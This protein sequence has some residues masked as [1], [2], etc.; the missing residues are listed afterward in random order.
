M[1]NNSQN[2]TPKK[3][4]GGRYTAAERKKI[5]DFYLDALVKT[6]GIKSPAREAA[7]GVSYVTIE[8]WKKKDPSFAA[9]EAE[10]LERGTEA[11]GDLAEGKLMQR[12]NGGDT[13]AIIFALKTKFKNRGYI[14][15]REIA[16]N[17][18]GIAQTILVNDSKEKAALENLDNLGV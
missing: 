15:K 18:D 11:F 5:Q 2:S 6:G 4:G 7:R 8:D 3:R 14:E 1:D 16:A 9:A 13:T 12:V 17:V 10:A